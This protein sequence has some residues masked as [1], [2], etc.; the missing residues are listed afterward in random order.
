[1]RP[2]TVV[3]GSP[4]VDK[5]LGMP[6]G[7]KDLHVQQLV[8]K[9]G[10]EAL[11]NAVLPGL[12]WI[13]VLFDHPLF[14]EPVAQ[15]VGDEFWAVIA[16][17]HHRNTVGLERGLQHGLHVHG[18]EGRATADGQGAAGEFVGQGQDLQ[19]RSLAGL[20]EDE[21]VGP[22]VV[23]MLSLQRK[24]LSCTYLSAQS[25]GWEGEAFA[26]PDL[27]DRL[28]VYHHALPQEGG[29][30]SSTSPARVPERQ[31]LDP[32][33]KGVIV[34]GMRPVRQRRARQ[35]EELARP[36]DPDAVLDEGVRGFPAFGSR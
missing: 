28:A 20:V 14:C 18:R 30:N 36:V 25:P 9:S 35:T 11:S 1:M 7:S 17:Q 19:G 21:I 6:G 4:G 16:A 13:D 32:R 27:V 12:P 29:M 23:R 22:D 2:N 24:M 15:V 8:A 31:G 33:W 34:P 10:M 26:L 3:E 5:H